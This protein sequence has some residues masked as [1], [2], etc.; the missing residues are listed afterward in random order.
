MSLTRK[1]LLDIVEETL[2]KRT[3]LLTTGQ[4]AQ[5]VNRSRSEV[6]RD[7]MSGAIQGH[8]RQARVKHQWRIPIEE[9]GKYLE[10]GFAAANQSRR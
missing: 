10:V 2:G 8:Q 3:L 5:I 6:W 1:E 9:L 7:L 4:F